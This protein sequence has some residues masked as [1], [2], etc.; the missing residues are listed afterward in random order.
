MRADYIDYET[1]QPLV[2]LT[3]T[4]PPENVINFMALFPNVYYYIGNLEHPDPLLMS[5]LARTWTLALLSDPSAVD[6]GTDID[7]AVRDSTAI[8]ISRSVMLNFPKVGFKLG[9]K[10]LDNIYAFPH[11]SL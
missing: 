4:T 6:D 9:F 11:L 10:F 8:T 2:F 7:V 5:C 3:L 1:L